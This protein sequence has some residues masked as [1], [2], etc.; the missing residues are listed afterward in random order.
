MNRTI[1][2]AAL[3]LGMALGAA[4][5]PAIASI[6]LL[7]NPGF[8]DGG[9]SYAGWFTFGSGVQLSL[10]APGDDIIRTGAA[11]SKI[12][13]GFAGCPG[14]PSFSVGGYG[15]A[16]TPTP[17]MEYE[18]SGYSFV[19][20]ADPIPGTDT[21]NG[22]RLI[23][24]VVFFNA[25]SGGAEI[26]SS[27]VVIGD[28]AT[29]ANRWNY[30][31]VSA[32]APPGA[33]RVEALFLYLQPGCDPGA[34]FVDDVSFCA[35][36]PESSPNSLVNP[37]FTV[38]LAGWSTFGNVFYDARAFLVRSPAG[39]AKLFSTFVADSPSGLFQG[40]NTTPGTAWRLDVHT[41]VTCRENPIDGTNDNFGLGRIV[42]RDAGNNEIASTDVLLADN[43]SPLGKWVRNAT[44]AIAPVGTARVEAYILFIS[45]TLQG[46]A[47][48]VDDVV[49]REVAVSDVPEAPRP[50]AFRLGQNHPNPFRPS[51]RIDFSLAVPADIRIA[52]FDV[53]GREVT[54]LVD[55]RIEAGDHA[56]EWDGRSKDGR[57][58]PAGVYHYV[59]TSP[60]GRTSR[61]MVLAD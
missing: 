57:R 54:R 3:A 58:A 49:F 20:A 42:F 13:G 59:L 35:L 24:K 43:A 5:S 34:V 22:N 50:A 28:H 7:A 55:G 27:E 18:L 8:E 6:N 39:S 26:A 9:G 41:L 48:W 31:S 37:A 10:P 15:Q 44:H 2:I 23:A 25:A 17:G 14:T 52:V 19:S 45:P 30:F 51:T 40:F 32:P 56:V 47:F 29:P 61:R 46:G 53:A 21:C 1:R 11:A 16:F 36:V 38:G 4:G 33:L 60:E 12:F